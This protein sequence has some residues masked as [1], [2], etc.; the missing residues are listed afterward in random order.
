[1]LFL[2]L[3]LLTLPAPVLPEASVM[4]SAARPTAVDATALNEARTNLAT[5]ES[6]PR[7]IHTLLRAAGDRAVYAGCVAERLTEAQVH[8]SIAREEMQRL[9]A[10]A[11]SAAEQAHAR[12]RLAMLAQRTREVTHAAVSCVDEDDSSISATKFETHVPPALQKKGDAT[13]PPPLPYPCPGVACIV[14]PEP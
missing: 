4:E 3:R 12:A 13:R 5:V 11:S 7:K 8:V 1:M 9:A 6:A 14:V 10:P 2:L